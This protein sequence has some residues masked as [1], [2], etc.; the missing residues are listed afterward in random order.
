MEC[1][2]KLI[3]QGW[4]ED[5]P[6]VRYFSYELVR[7]DL[8]LRTEELVQSSQGERSLTL[9]H[10]VI[11]WGKVAKYL[12]QH[13]HS[14]DGL[15]VYGHL[16]YRRETDREGVSKVITEIEAVKVELIAPKAVPQASPK[17]QVQPDSP[18]LPWET[19]SPTEYE[20]PMA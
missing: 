11:A 2:N 6:S 9:W 1:I 20:D 15:K 12:D 18:E 17:P 13:V 8:R 16:R 4:V 5:N 3:L 10:R 19:F 7:T 14:G